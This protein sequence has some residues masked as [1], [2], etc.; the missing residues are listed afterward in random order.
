MQCYRAI[1]F[2]ILGRVPRQENVMAMK[3]RSMFSRVVPLLL[4][5]LRSLPTAYWC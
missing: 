4:A 1:L 3:Q 2:P 5:V